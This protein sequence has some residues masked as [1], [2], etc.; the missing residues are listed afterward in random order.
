M[1]V[2]Y[3]LLGGPDVSQRCDPFVKGIVT[4]DRFFV[5]SIIDFLQIVLRVCI[6][7]KHAEKLWQ[8]ICKQNSQFMYVPGT[9]DLLV[10]S[11]KMP[12]NKPTA[13]TTVAGL[14][15]VLDVL[16]RNHVTDANR[17]VLEDIFARHAAGDWSMIVQI[18]LNEKEHKIPRFN[19]NFQPPSVS[20]EPVASVIIEEAGAG[21]I[22]ASYGDS[23]PFL[24]PRILTEVG[25]TSNSSYSWK[26]Y[27]SII[28]YTY[29]IR[30]RYICRYKWVC[31]STKDKFRQ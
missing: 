28:N 14:K 2:A 25:F 16:S 10:P 6:N 29:K 15:A 11:K 18:D 30:K 9:L 23:P 13:G 7:R 22:P 4:P 21:P 19:Y 31:S 17:K 8:T 26:F 3:L 12:E 20:H 5:F 24:L 1:S 27:Q